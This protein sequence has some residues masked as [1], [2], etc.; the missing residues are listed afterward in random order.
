MVTLSLPTPIK[1]E[2][3]CSQ[4]KQYDRGICRLKAEAD[5][6]DSAKTSPKRKACYFADLLPF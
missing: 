4:C 1:T 2:P 6:G 5:W 3:T